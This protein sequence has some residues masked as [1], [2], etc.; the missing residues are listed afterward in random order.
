MKKI[1]LLFLTLFTV[2]FGYSQ[3]THTI[4]FEPAGTGSG[5]SWIAGEIAPSFAEITNPVS[6]GINT[7]ATVVE[8]VAR[9]VD[10]PWAL[11]HTD[12][13]KTFTFDATNS[14]VKI[15]VYK[16]RISDVGFKFEGASPAI[17]LKVANTVINQWEELTFDFSGQVG[18]TYTKIVL[19]PD[20]LA[21]ASDNTLYLDNIQV[22]EGVVVE[23]CSDGIINNSETEID[24]GGPN[25]E[26]CALPVS[27]PT[28][29]ATTPP[30]RDAADVVSIYSDAYTS[31]SPINYDAGW[32]G[33]TGAV[34][35]TT[36]AGD[37]I[38]AYN[39]KTCQGIDFDTNK[40]DI[41]GF[42]DL[43]I[44]LFIAAG[45]DLVGKVF[46]LKIET[47]DSNIS[48]PIDVN[49]L[50]PAP[51]PGTW[52]SFDKTIINT[53]ASVMMRQFVIT[54]NLNNAIWY[55]N[56]YLHKVTLTPGT[57]SDGVMNQD[58]TGIDCG[59]TISGCE[60]CTG[61]PSTAAPTPESRDAANVISF[62]SDAYTD[63]AIDDFDSNL[64]SADNAVAEVIIDG[65]ATQ[66]YLGKGCQGIDVQNNRIDAS[67]FTN[68][69]FDFYTDETD[70]I[71]KVFNIKLVDWAGNTTE[72]GSS[73]L[74]INFNDGSGLVSGAWVSIDVD[75][76]ALGGRISG[77][78]TRSDIAQ[79]HITSNLANAWYDNLYLYK[80]T[81]I[82]PTVPT[83]S[84][85]TPTNN[86]DYVISVYSDAYTDVTTNFNPPWGQTGAVNETFDTSG[87][88]TNFAMAYTNFNY[89]G[90]V[91]TTQD[92]SEME[93]LHVDIWTANATD[94]KVSPINKGDGATGPV[95]FLASVTLVNGGW[96]SVDI[97]KSAFTGMTWDSV[98]E[99]KFDG[100]G[101]VNPSDI[102]LDNIYFWKEQPT[103][104]STSAPTPT[105][106][107]ADV[108]SIYSDSYTDIATNYNP[109]WGQTGAVNEIFDTSGDGTNFAMAY[110][111][112]NY[113]GT[114]VTTQ[115][116]SGMEYLHVDIWT[117]N[118]TDIKV[119]PVNKGDGAT[120]P[121]EF[122]A[123]VT[124]VNGGWSSVDIPKSAFTGMTWDSVVELKFDGQGGVNPSDIYLDNIYFW[125]EP[126]LGIND[127]EIEDLQAYP[128][129]TSNQWTISTKDQVINSIDVYDVSGKKVI[130]L[131]PN[132]I[133][134]TVDASSL[135]AGMYISTIT[136]SLGTI[137]RKLIKK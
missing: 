64:C 43:H 132:A 15:M 81:V 103:S 19:I 137:S 38:F 76:T 97:P 78:L 30:S 58:E 82:A 33:G 112:F 55:D 108:I 47:A 45:T 74:E 69:H 62:Y 24:C 79:I 87:D 135:T 111:N 18:N 31:I 50:S 83:T 44:D 11:A 16:S 84:A 25:C 120:G 10:N 80:E 133:S 61:P 60:P 117:A 40:Q 14:T 20:F 134:T 26:P 110:T 121:V 21:R 86:A 107:A 41:T 100:Q 57:C 131:Q 46:N 34:T 37:N 56:L 92:A 35:E 124:L 4:N 113:Q 67:S 2:S 129:P 71:G 99:L 52:Y 42:T 88:G 122:L 13:N 49:G 54:S 23:T 7:S 17:E 63:T 104:P 59:G 127:I 118:A 91:I 68:I 32:C 136:T 128:N 101:G 85:P 22:P 48:I 27:P 8:F 98:A 94:I 126:L 125:K 123:S 51:V 93:Y 75:I 70:L 96:S 116:A 9:S 114:V 109:N 119:S 73:G 130:S 39:D 89:Q 65:N 90:T 6:G 102:Y 105:K 12:D 36:A 106:T 115:D 53:G 29:S 28:V 5:W 3:A 77:N 66:N 72:S 1:T 95:E